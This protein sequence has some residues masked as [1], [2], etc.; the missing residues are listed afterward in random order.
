MLQLLIL[1]HDLIYNMKLKE[2]FEESKLVMEENLSLSK[3]EV[4]FLKE[5]LKNY[6]DNANEEQFKLFENEIMKIRE[7]L[8]EKTMDFLKVENVH[9]KNYEELTK[10]YNQ[11]KHNLEEMKEENIKYAEAM[12]NISTNLNQNNLK[13]ANEIVKHMTENTNNPTVNLESQQKINAMNT[14]DETENTNM[15]G[16]FEDRSDPSL[17]LNNEKSSTFAN[18]VIAEFDK[19]FNNEIKRLQNHYKKPEELK[20]VKRSSYVKRSSG[21]KNYIAYNGKSPNQKFAEGLRNTDRSQ[22]DLNRSRM[23]K[24][25]GSFAN[26]FSMLFDKKSSNLNMSGNSD[27]D[28]MLYQAKDRVRSSIFQGKNTFSNSNSHNAISANKM[29]IM[30]H[31]PIRNDEEVSMSR[32]KSSEF[33]NSK[34]NIK[35]YNLSPTKKNLG[36][37]AGKS[38]G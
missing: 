36:H 2:G 6:D 4:T 19:V 27:L 10:N 12:K 3:Q 35:A 38:R 20:Q 28:S 24:T 31:S 17:I 11:V 8:N 5:R 18:K 29:K 32:D 30:G 16:F 22:E 23:N 14:F 21:V 26:N 34:N 33:K 37:S 1:E 25:D 13:E 15:G 9:K 7:M